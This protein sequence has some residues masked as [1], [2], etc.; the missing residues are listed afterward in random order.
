MD[1][2]FALPWTSS[3]QRDSTISICWN[4]LESMMRSLR[5][6]LLTL[7]TC[8][9]ACTMSHVN[10]SRLQAQ[11]PCCPQCGCVTEFREVTQTVCRMVPETKPIKKIVYE[12]KRVPYCMHCLSGICRSGRCTQC[13]G[14]ARW[15]TVLVKKEITCGEKTELKCVTEEIKTLVPVTCQKCIPR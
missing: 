7:S 13:E 4:L 12:T 9:I 3:L 6:C 15:K 11:E 1:S 2:V 14:S 10:R 8:F 5:L